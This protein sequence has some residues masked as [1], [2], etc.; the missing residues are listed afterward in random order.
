MERI[1]TTAGYEFELAA[2]ASVGVGKKAGLNSSELL[3]RVHRSVGDNAPKITCSHVVDVE[4]IHRNSTLIHA[5]ARYRAVQGRA[6]LLHE[7]RRGTAP[8]LDRQI[9]QHLHLNIVA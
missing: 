4:A 3:D 6:R 1:G 9:I 7:E 2:T 5:G 8:I